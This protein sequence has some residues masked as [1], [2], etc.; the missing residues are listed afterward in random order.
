MTTSEALAFAMTCVVAMRKK[1]INSEENFNREVLIP[2]IQE[3]EKELGIKPPILSEETG[4]T[5]EEERPDIK[6][7]QVL[8]VLETAYNEFEDFE[9]EHGEEEIWELQ[10]SDSLGS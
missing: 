10:P 3:V 6:Y 8:D 9:G 5:L 1:A 2:A 4:I 7:N